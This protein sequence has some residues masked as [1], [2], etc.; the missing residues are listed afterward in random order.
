V[1]VDTTGVVVRDAVGDA[2]LHEARD[3]FGGFDLPAALVGM[4]TALALTTILAGL[5]T[6]AIGAIGYQIGL[7]EAAASVEDAATE[8]TVAGLVG[9]IAVLFLAFLVGG[10]AAARI[11]RYD[12]PTNGVMTGVWTLVLGAVLSALGAIAGAEYDVLARV[13]LPQWFSRDAL[14]VGAI[15]T[16]LVA[17]ATML[18]AGAIGGR[19]GERF[20]RRADALIAHTRTGG[21]EREAGD[22]LVRR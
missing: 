17:V 22:R 11:A 4:L 2:G 8:T 18:V 14:T 21:I 19:W 1:N 16:G 13:D 10:W 9:G 12:G 15:V 6:A 3:R 5:I 7:D 20:H